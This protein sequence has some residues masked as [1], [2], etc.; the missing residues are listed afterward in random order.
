MTKSKLRLLVTRLAFLGLATAVVRA[1]QP[2][3]ASATTS[4]SQVFTVAAGGNNLSDFVSSLINTQGQFQS[5]KGFA[6]SGSMRY[7]GVANAITF[8]SNTGQTS[9]TLNFNPIG[10]NKVFTGSSAQEVDDLVDDYFKKDGL[11]VVARFLKAIAAQSAIAVT[12]GNPNSATASAANNLFMTQGFTSTDEIADGMDNASGSGAPTKPRFGG[13]AI[14]FNSGHFKAGGFSGTNTDFSAS[15]LNFG[16]E[17]VRFVGS[18]GA[19]LLDVEGAKVYG[20]TVNFALPIR[21][22]TMSKDKP[23]NWRLTP[24]AGISARASA[25]LGDGALLWQAGLAN[26]IDYKVAPKLVVCMV[27]QFT[28]H[29]SIALDY[30]DYSFD[31]RI[32]QQMAKNGLRFVTPLTPRLI[33]DFFVLDTRYLKTAAVKS[34]ETVGASI[35]LRATKTFNLGLAANYDTGSNY[36]AWSV[37]LSSA[38]HW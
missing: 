33:G 29:K 25:D 20:A 31:P 12:D 13:F 34:F 38:W 22:N 11:D 14:G 16:G 7:L 8:G 15:V 6:Y 27:N 21:F 36:K 1:D 26:T 10:V 9:V 17:K 28:F 4:G 30:D 3:F 37:G 35:S 2:F 32:D 23:Y 18:L 24:L 5:L 19:S